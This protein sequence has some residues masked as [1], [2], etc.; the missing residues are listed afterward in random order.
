[1]SVFINN[2]S[3]N[4]LQLV[5]QQYTQNDTS[6]KIATCA[7]VNN[8]VS[9]AD[10]SINVLNTAVGSLYSAVGP[11]S[12]TVSSL[13]GSVSTLSGTVGTL[14][15]TVGTLSSTV[16]T[17]SGK[18]TDISSSLATLTT[19]VDTKATKTLVDASFS[20]LKSSV[21]VSFTDVYTNISNLGNNS[22]SFTLDQAVLQIEMENARDLPVFAQN[23]MRNTSIN[24]S[25]N[26]ASLSNCIACSGNGQYIFIGLQGSQ[27]GNT[28]PQLSKDYG[29]TWTDVTPAFGLAFENAT[30]AA[31]SSTG[32][33]MIAINTNNGVSLSGGTYYSIDYGS[34]W[35]RGSSSGT[36]SDS[37]AISSTGKYMLSANKSNIVISNNYGLDNADTTSSWYY[38]N[39]SQLDPS[40]N[41]S[42]NN[43]TYRAVSMAHDASIM[44][45]TTKYRV[46]K[47]TDFGNEWTASNST[48][49]NYG[50]IACSANG[51]YV[52]VCPFQ[53]GNDT[54]DNLYV[55]NNYGVTF[56]TVGDVH[57][58]CACAVSACGRYMIATDKGK[59]TGNATPLLNRKGY[60]Y[61]SKNYGADWIQVTDISGYYTGIAMSHNGDMIY[62][63][64]STSYGDSGRLFVSN[65]NYSTCVQT[66]E[67]Y[68][69]VHSGTMYYDKTTNEL[70]IYNNDQWYAVTF[71]STLV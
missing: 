1:M 4:S 66:V 67:P 49:T 36:P 9:R 15:G 31:I 55:S 14:S 68:G 8:R 2:S 39:S 46:W 65:S 59:F 13:S 20:A 25:A 45:A 17:V 34:T 40:Y 70:K 53:S 11:L 43:G 64:S 28:V 7:F 60:V 48:G 30:A 23:W 6:N 57:S 44:Y 54:S 35:V 52:L 19:T 58:Y 51:Q 42:N 5:G 32:Q 61:A 71:T 26:N 12:S 33:Y 50:N 37:V 69:T 27:I 62:S 22:S 41:A 38:G 3:P 56:T 63:Q 47:S 29:N 16:S 10:I 24:Y 18:V 21:D